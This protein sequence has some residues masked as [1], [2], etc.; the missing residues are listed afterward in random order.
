VLEPE[1]VPRWYVQLLRRRRALAAQMFVTAALTAGLALWAIAG[2]RQ[3]RAADTT[4]GHVQAQLAATGVDLQ[5]LN[6]LSTIQHQLEQQDQIV[7]EL[8]VHV[9]VSRMLTALRD[10]MPPRMA[11]RDL[12]IQTV[13]TVETLTEAQRAKG[14][15]PKVSRSLRVTLVGVAPTQ[16]EL[17]TF[18]TEVV[19]VPFF[20]DFEFVKSEELAEDGH[21][22]RSLQAKFSLNLD[23]DPLRSAA[24]VTAQTEQGTLP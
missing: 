3:V 5:R 9:P 11:L 1:F 20:T 13:E 6:D 24:G 8:G 23:G 16:D 2:L 4:L 21:L 17:A 18:V 10:L 15:T 19:A 12:S 7:R 22:L 14:Q